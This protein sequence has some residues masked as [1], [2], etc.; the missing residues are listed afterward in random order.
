[1]PF[2]L[3]HHT[4][5]YKRVQTRCDNLHNSPHFGI[6]YCLLLSHGLLPS[7]THNYGLFEFKNLFKH[8]KFERKC[9]FHGSLQFFIMHPI[10]RTSLLLLLNAFPQLFGP[11]F[12]FYKL[13]RTSFIFMCFN[14]LKTLSLFVAYWYALKITSCPKQLLSLKS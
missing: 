7:I 8:N 14:K 10:V 9:G 3:I 2:W 4:W 13:V 11:C 12:V 5:R 6:R 1:M